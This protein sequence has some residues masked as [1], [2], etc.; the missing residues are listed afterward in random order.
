M[1]Q[2]GKSI[3]KNIYLFFLSFFY[4]GLIS[5]KIPGTV[6]SFFAMLIVYAIPKSSSLITF[7]SI[8]LF[9]A[10]TILSDIYLIRYKYDENRDPSYI[11]ID[12]AC[13][14][15]LGAALVSYFGVL[16]NISIFV[17]FLLFRFFD[18]LKPFPI[19]QIEATLKNN[20][21]TVG[22]GIMLDDVLAAIF[23]STLQVAGGVLWA[24]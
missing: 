5:K 1:E 15:F 2:S 13:G 20:N 16:D 19:K 12:E 6:G 18:I 11:V 23:S 10:G 4:T 3:R 8:L 21:K 9:I 17:N 24:K 7:V 22:F 14:I